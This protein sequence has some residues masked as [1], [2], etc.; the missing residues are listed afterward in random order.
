MIHRY[1]RGLAFP[2]FETAYVEYLRRHTVPHLQEL[3]GF[4]G[5]S[6]LKRRDSAGTE[7][8]VITRWD[9]LQSIAAFAGNDAES[10]VVP[11]D[12]RRMMREYDSRARHYEQAL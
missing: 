12:V 5:I 6:V 3:P 10:A 4:R 8:M 1:W 7:F 11:E 9:A 2:E